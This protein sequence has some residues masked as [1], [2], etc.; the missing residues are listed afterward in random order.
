MSSKYH[1][2]VVTSAVTLNAGDRI[3]VEFG[4]RAQNTSTTSYSGTIRYGGSGTTDL[5]A[6]DG[7][8]AVSTRWPWVQ[9]SANIVTPD[10]QLL[11]PVSIFTNSNSLALDHT[12][13]K[14][15]T[16]AQSSTYSDTDSLAYQ[17]VV[18]TPTPQTLTQTS[19]FGNSNTLN[20]QAT[21]S[22]LYSLIQTARFNATN[23]LSYTHSLTSI[24]NL[25]QSARFDNSN[26]LSFQQTLTSVRALI[27]SATFSDTDSLAYNHS[28]LSVYPIVAT[29]YSNTNSL[30][31]D[32]SIIQQVPYPQVL[33]SPFWPCGR[34]IYPPRIIQVGTLYSD[35]TVTSSNSF[36]STTVD[37]AGNILKVA[38]FNNFSI[39][40]VAKVDAGRSQ[41]IGVKRTY[42][43]NS[44]YSHMV[45]R[46]QKIRPAPYWNRQTDLGHTIN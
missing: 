41:Y 2:Q 46:N 26:S 45:I 19:S 34:V 37:E 25:T 23:S 30:A 17:H 31:F 35:E 28:S 10:L 38:R 8:T 36:Y 39:V 15:N 42:L 29:L 21:L 32:A 3:V 4:Y 18:L 5:N 43:A 6:A 14:S 20:Y 40:Y 16:L 24:R 44:F 33:Q 27:Q 1:S 12:L 11:T 22:T 7:D 9:F 13:T